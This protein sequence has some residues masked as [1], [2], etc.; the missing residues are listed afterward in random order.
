MDTAHGTLD[1]NLHDLRPAGSA[2]AASY[3]FSYAY[4]ASPALLAE[5][6]VRRR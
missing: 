2:W 1:L 6:E 4:Y 5:Q 3:W